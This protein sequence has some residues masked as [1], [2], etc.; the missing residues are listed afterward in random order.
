MTCEGVSGRVVMCEGG[1]GRG[2]VTCERGR[3]ESGDVWKKTSTSSR[4]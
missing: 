3:G 4:R 1:R 2:R